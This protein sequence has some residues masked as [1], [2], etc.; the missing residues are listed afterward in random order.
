MRSGHRN[1]F[2]STFFS[3]LKIVNSFKINAVR[4]INL[5]HKAYEVTNVKLKKAESWI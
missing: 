4:I 2:N 3:A 5:M 1:G